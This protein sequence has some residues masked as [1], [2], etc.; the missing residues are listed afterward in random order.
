[1]G[2]WLP[3]ECHFISLVGFLLKDDDNSVRLSLKTDSCP[4]RVSGLS[5]GDCYSIRAFHCSSPEHGF[6]LDWAA[7]TTAVCNT[8]SERMVHVL[9]ACFLC[10]AFQVELSMED[11]ET[12]LNTLIYDGKVEMTII[13]AKE[14]TVGSVDGHM[15]L[16]RAVNPILPPTGVVRA[17]CGLCPV[18]ESC[19]TVV[20]LPIICRCHKETT[21]T[22]GFPPVSAT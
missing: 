4:Q 15:K 17:P 16:Y 7:V 18:S 1:M 2:F 6:T 9:H 19:F 13:A 11:I 3:K 5:H 12:I 21:G 14:G 8:F 20:S 22:A 10:T